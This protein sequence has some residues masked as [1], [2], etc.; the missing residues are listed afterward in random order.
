MSGEGVDYHSGPYTATFSA[1]ATT[2]TFDI[3]ISNDDM[4]RG[5]RRFQLAVDPSSLP[6]NV[7]IGNTGQATVTIVDDDCKYIFVILTIFNVCV[8]TLS[9][10]Y[11]YTAVYIKTT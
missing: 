8:C 7:T 4:F 10:C 9:R 2:T 6:S 3:I 5:A 11:S 1:G